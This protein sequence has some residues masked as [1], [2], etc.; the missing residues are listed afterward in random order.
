MK[1]PVKFIIGLLA[2]V[3]GITGS[4]ICLLPRYGP[5]KVV[6]NYISAAEKG[7]AEKMYEYTTQ[8]DVSN[9][10]NNMFGSYYTDE[11]ETIEIETETETSVSTSLL[12]QILPVPDAAKEVTSA[13]VLGCDYETFSELGI[14]GYKVKA[15]VKLSYTDDEDKEFTE[16]LTKTY[17]VVKI[18]NAY[19]IIMF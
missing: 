7:N 17:S 4:L 18:E 3:I 14:M 11:D 1:F 6:Y 8:K 16:V 19:K 13:K 12:S 10:L 15:L 2:L 5:E 9:A